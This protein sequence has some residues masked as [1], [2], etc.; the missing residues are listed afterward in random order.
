MRTKDGETIRRCL[1]GEPEAFG[2]LVDKYKSSIYAFAYTKLG[3][4][5]DAEDVTRKI[6]L[7]AYRN[8]RKLRRWDSFFAWLCSITSNLCEYW[9]IEQARRP[10]R[11]SIHDHLPEAMDNRSV[12]SHQDNELHETLHAALSSL[13]DMYRQALVLYY[14]GDMNTFEIAS[15][16]GASP[17]TIRKRLSSVNSG[18]K[19]PGIPVQ[20]SP[21]FSHNLS[22]RLVDAQQVK[23]EGER[24]CWDSWKE[25]P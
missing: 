21:P 3:N 14:F 20:E 10:D 17:T 7:K 9:I 25:A 15:F 5:Q 12:K 19:V 18:S 24:G 13:P 4:F 6:F 23:M 16:L 8:L 2:F 1:D 11:E 22:I